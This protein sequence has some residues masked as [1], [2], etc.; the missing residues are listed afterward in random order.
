MRSAT[1]NSI[2][3]ASR[4]RLRRARSSARPVG[5]VPRGRSDS[6][7]TT[8]LLRAIGAAILVS[9][10][11]AAATAVMQPADAPD[12]DAVEYRI[13][14][15]HVFPMTLAQS[16]RAQMRIQRL[17]GDLGLWF[18]EFDVGL[19]SCFRPPRLAWTLLLL[20]TVIGVGCLN[21]A[22]LN[23]ED[24]DDPPGRAG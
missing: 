21:L 3:R 6:R 13:V 7:R 16:R 10:W 15:G 20:S 2:D 23:A 1:A 19:R 17:N 5:P 8:L 11:L 9:G 12:A 14:D 4:R 24:S 22:K 18:A